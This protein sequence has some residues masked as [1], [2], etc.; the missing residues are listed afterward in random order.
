VTISRVQL[1]W[2]SSQ[3]DLKK[4]SLSGSLIWVGS[5][6]PFSADISGGWSDPG[7]LVL[8]A[9]QTGTLDFDFKR[10]DKNDSQ[11]DYSITVDFAEGCSVQF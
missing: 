8:G 3:G 5:D 11:S 4:I 7:A 9:G 2:P 10:R 6:A 1:S